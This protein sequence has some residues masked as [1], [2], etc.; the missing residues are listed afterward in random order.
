M[1]LSA[2]DSA[3]LTDV[4]QLMRNAAIDGGLTPVL[5]VAAAPYFRMDLLPP[6]VD[7][8]AGFGVAVVLS[9]AGSL[10][11]TNGEPVAITP[12]TVVP[13][14][15]GDWHVEGDVRSPVCRPGD[16]WPPQRTPNTWEGT[17]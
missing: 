13:A 2:V 9:G 6:G 8:P 4:A 7:V 1:A 3:A 16:S 5:P 11:A 15:C 17:A 12:E 10:R 14:S